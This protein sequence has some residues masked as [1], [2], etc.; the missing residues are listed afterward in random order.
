MK[1]VI[2]DRF[3]KEGTERLASAGLE[4][5]DVP[6]R[7][8][9]GGGG[10]GPDPALVE[11]LVGAHALVIRS[12]TKVDPALLEAAPSLVLV[13]R[14]GVGYENID[15]Q[16]CSRL[17]IAVM[18][19]PGASAITTGERTIAMMLAMLHQVPT[20]DRSVRAGKWERRAFM[21]SE[22]F[23]KTLGILGY[24]NVGRVVADRAAA[25]RMRVIAHDPEVPDEAIFNLG[26]RPVGFHE[27]FEQSDIVS[28]HV[29]ADPK[30]THLV[31]KAELSQMKKG[32]WLVNTARGFVLDEA[33]LAEALRSGHL[34]GAALD[35]FESEP[36]PEGSLLRE[37]DNVVL[38]PHLGASSSEAERR[39]AL[40]LADQ[41]ARFLLKGTASNL[42]T[43]PPHF[44]HAMVGA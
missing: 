36:L 14:A 23:D 6:P 22:A 27:L 3:A 42:V 44:R 40:A 21:A 28:I 35:V 43:R 37:L 2:T 10:A 5:V 17:G 11:A 39:V 38:S 4:V 1:V 30:L 9:R 33:A 18:N 29:R 7:E 34:R 15:V 13:G 26:L 24:G 41:V 20:A 8:R 25:L 31:G 32:A 12:Q 19:T 16:A